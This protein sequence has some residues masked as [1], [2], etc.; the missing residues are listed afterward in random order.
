MDWFHLNKI[1]NISRNNI[2]LLILII[3]IMKSLIILITLATF[4][5]VGSVLFY[6]N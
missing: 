3:I 5:T 4:V 6:I 1:Y 2:Y